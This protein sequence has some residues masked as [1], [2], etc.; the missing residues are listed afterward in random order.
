MRNASA[1]KSTPA[2]PAVAAPT[3]AAAAPANAVQRTG[4][5]P[6]PTGQTVDFTEPVVRQYERQYKT[7]FSDPADEGATA[8]AIPA[9]GEIDAAMPAAGDEGA[10]KPVEAKAKPARASSFSDRMNT[11]AEPAATATATATT[12]ETATA[13]AVATTAETPAVPVLTRDERRRALADIDAESNRRQSEQSLAAERTRIAA[14]EAKLK[15]PLEERLAL[16]FPGMSR[17]E[18]IEGL[19]SGQIKVPDAAAAPAKKTPEQE[20]IEQLERDIAELKGT[21]PAKQDDLAI[22]RLRAV[23]ANVVATGVPLPFSTKAGAEADAMRLKV[24]KALW[25]MQGEKGQVDGV[26]VCQVV[27]EHFEGQF[28]A[29]YGDEAAKVIKGA[30]PTAAAPVVAAPAATSQRRPAVGRR[31]AHAS[32][33]NAD[34]LPMN[35]DARHRVMMKEIDQIEG[36]IAFGPR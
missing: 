36:T 27:E 26:R 4:D 7:D 33:T 13:T 21:S 34:P 16:A 20:R 24:T 14:V 3:P 17:D 9:A 25:K 32:P 19:V 1:P 31:G 15:G 6:N 35:Q 10:A 12:T 28:V 8:R 5:I 2:A 30:K 22:Q 18:L 29:R 11:D 23:A